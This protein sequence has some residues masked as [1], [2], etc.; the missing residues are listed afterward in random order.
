MQRDLQAFVKDWNTH[1][2]RR[3]PNTDSPHGCP[4]DNYD[5]PTVHGNPS[6][7]YT[8]HLSCYYYYIPGKS[9][10]L[11]PVNGRL[12]AR[13]MQE[14][15]LAPPVCPVLFKDAVEAVL[16]STLGLSV[17]DI[18]HANCRNIYLHLVHQMVSL[19]GDGFRL[20]LSD[21]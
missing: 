5:M 20:P 15:V 6:C 17:N 13:G 18:T 12:W 21:L 16:R 11:M 10:Q 1:P 4:E 7:A 2:I 3:N 8:E 19:I 14:T 9:D